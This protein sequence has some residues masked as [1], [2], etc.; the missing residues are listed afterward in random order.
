MSYTHFTRYERNFIE[1]NLKL[2]FSRRYIAKKS[3]RH[4]SSVCDEINRNSDKNGEYRANFADFE[5]IKRRVYRE[6][7][8]KD[9][10]FLTAYI[11]EK[12]LKTW[13]PEQISNRLK[14]EY[15]DDK[16][17][18]LS[19]SKIYSMI[20]SRQIA[21]ITKKH[22]RKK[23]KRFLHTKWN[24]QIEGAVH[25]SKRSKR[26]D[27]RSEIGHWEI[28][29]VVSSKSKSRLGTFVDRKSRY[30]VISLLKNGT[31][32]EFNYGATKKFLYIPKYKRKTFTSDNGNEFAE[33]IEL[34]QILELKT[35]F[36]D[37]HSPWQRPTNENTNGLIREFYPKKFDFS[38]ITQKDV[39]RV[40]ELINNRPRKCLGW[41][42]ATEV[43]KNRSKV[44]IKNN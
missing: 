27:D 5:Y 2:G 31:S 23:G 28:D 36:T 8:S 37:K 9:V 18:Q 20:Y 12:I 41:L 3:G 29:S 7:T 21:G 13:S 26:A 34:G 17:K 22:L 15:P 6:Y 33:H 25:I 30:L 10:L 11:R 38:T 24:N 39:D 43:F 1:E 44:I 40:A 19:T 16:R 35:Y 32:D 42:S 14:F 4:H